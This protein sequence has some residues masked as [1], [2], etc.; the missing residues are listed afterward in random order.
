MYKYKVHKILV[1]YST[2]HRISIRRMALPCTVSLACVAGA[3]WDTFLIG[4][5]LYSPSSEPSRTVLFFEV[6]Y[7]TD[8]RQRC[9]SNS[10]PWAA[11][12][13][14]P[15]DSATSWLRRQ[16]RFSLNSSL[17]QGDYFL[18]K[19]FFSLKRKVGK[20][21]FCPRNFSLFRFRLFSNKFLFTLKFSQHFRPSKFSRPFRFETFCFSS[22]EM[23][24]RGGMQDR[25]NTGQRYPGQVGRIHPEEVHMRLF[26]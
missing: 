14:P 19:Y 23:C 18:V 17:L 2:H 24:W 10:P 3:T 4:K 16:R 25:R 12:F 20:L 13:I 6:M 8:A 22:Q 26:S 7:T 5:L 15:W 11:P 21:N 1:K 9:I